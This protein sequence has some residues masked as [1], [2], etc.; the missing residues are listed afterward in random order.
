M[1]PEF[2]D[3]RFFRQEPSQLRS[4]KYQTSIDENY[5]KL[6]AQSKARLNPTSIHNLGQV[7]VLEYDKDGNE[8]EGRARVCID[9]QLILKQSIGKCILYN[10]PIPSPKKLI[11]VIIK[12]CQTNASFQKL[13]YQIPFNSFLM[14]YLIYSL[15]HAPLAKFPALALLMVCS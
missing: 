3:K 13:I 6:I 4:K 15:L 1:K 11:S 9:A 10:F 2:K 8:V 12:F 7:I 5:K 14:N